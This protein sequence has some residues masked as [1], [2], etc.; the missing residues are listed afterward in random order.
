[1]FIPTSMADYAS[2]LHIALLDTNPQ[3]IDSA[4]EIITDAYKDGHTIYT[5]GNGGSAAIS[6]HL[7]CDCVKGVACDTNFLPRI[8]SLNCNDSMLTAIANDIGY[9]S[10]FSSQ[11]QWSAMAEEVLIAISSSGNSPNIIEALVMAKSLKMK[12]IS[13][14]GF[15]GGRAKN[16]S[17]VCIH[18]PA[19]NYGIVEDASQAVMHYIAQQIR[20]QNKNK[21][22]L[23]L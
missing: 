19:D 4:I 11:L 2:G 18:I 8:H 7:V 21:P 3:K 17:D 10:V 15:D 16:I 13:I 20:I 23:K 1:M 14:V 12:T 5:C 9:E 22:E 6:N